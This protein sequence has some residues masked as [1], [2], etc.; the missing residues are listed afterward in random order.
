MVTFLIDAMQR[1]SAKLPNNPACKVPELRCVPCPED[2]AATG[3]YEA[4]THSIL[5]CENFIENGLQAEDT[6]SH[7]LL[8]AYDHCRVYFDDANCQHVACSEIRAAN[9]SGDCK[10][11]R[12]LLRGKLFEGGSLHM[13]GKH[14]ECVRRR[15]LISMQSH[16]ACRD[17]PSH[18]LVQ[19]VDKVFDVCFADTAPFL[20]IP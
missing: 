5:L 11:S 18:Q 14:K 10:W 20:D 6:M 8:H 1:S 3:I 12:E 9:L 17:C 19:L 7:E 4:S 2:A 13:A 15:A 16:P